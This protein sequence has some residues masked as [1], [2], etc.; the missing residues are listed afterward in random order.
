MSDY[1]ASEQQQGDWD[2]DWVTCAVQEDLIWEASNGA[3]Q[4]R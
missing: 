1:V 4:D 2:G 3:S